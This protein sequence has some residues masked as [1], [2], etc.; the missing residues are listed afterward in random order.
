MQNSDEISY[1]KVAILTKSSKN[2]G[3]CVAGVN[4]DNKRLIRLV[5]NDNESHGALFNRHM[6]YQ[7]NTFCQVLDIAEVPV[8]GPKP[9]DFQPENILID[10]NHNWKKCRQSSIGEILNIFP[11]KYYENL[12]GN[13]Y[14]YITIEAISRV[15]YSLAW[16][17][18]KNL[19]ITRSDR[20]IKAEFQY[21]AQKYENISVT[22]PDYYST[23][24]PLQCNHAVLLVSLPDSPYKE[25]YFYKFIAK[26][27]R[28]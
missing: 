2:G 28:T 8:I 6:R 26:I 21:N 22:D 20:K 12:L 5:S 17:E 16:I 3:F 4:L 1:I 15:Q 23:A 25:R 14:N 24:L 9:I 7:D 13:P 27:F 10:E 19:I 18:V 11:P